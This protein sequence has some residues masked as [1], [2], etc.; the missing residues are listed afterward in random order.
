M[1]NALELQPERPLSTETQA[2]P[3]VQMT[4]VQMAYQLISSG[5]DFASV[6][7]MM[8]LSKEL[9]ADQARRAFDEAVASAKAGIPTIAK[10]AKGHNN[11]AYANFAAYAEAL[12][13]V[14]AQH[15]LS[16][17]FRTEQTDRITVT[18]VLSH[19]GGHSEENSL[20]GPADTSGSKN[21]IQAIGSTLT[22]LQR[23]TLVQALGLA[24]SDDDDGRASELEGPIT[25]EQATQLREKIDAVGADIQRFCNRWDI[26]ALPDLPASKFRDV[27]VSLERFGQQQK[28]GA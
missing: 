16:Y 9:A 27:M 6:K 26:E 21:A 25:A 4:P 24:A 3:L 11:K 20:S 2:V 28:Q 1:S 8:A 10:N 17:R 18:C 22:Y 23:Y 13:D 15:G 5:A 7:E 19:K 14:L 12:K